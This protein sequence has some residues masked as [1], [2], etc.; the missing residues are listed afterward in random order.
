MN[1]TNAILFFLQT[2]HYRDD[3]ES[4]LFE[5]LKKKTS[6]INENE[7]E[8][9]YGQRVHPELIKKTHA[10]LIDFRVLTKTSEGLELNN[11]RLEYFIK[12][13]EVAKAAREYNWPSNKP[14]PFLYISPPS[15]ITSD[16]SGDIDD[17]SNLLINLVRSANNTISIMS[18]FTNKEGLKSILSPLKACT[19]NPD[20][21]L[22]LTANEE[23]K[24]MI[25]KQIIQQVPEN[26]L[27]NLKLYYC[28]TELLETDNLPHAKLLIID[29]KK[30]YLGSANFTKQGLKSR[31]E[32][33]VELE[34]QQSKTVDKLL[35]MLV[36]QGTFQLFENSN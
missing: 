7:F 18:P 4:A 21:S 6:P 20:I 34:E 32:L 29:S 22:Y 14:K 9:I 10:T 8:N 30:G 3:L 19:N 5:N 33:G 28:S 12:L 35:S 13:T 31:F 15:L 23:D 2:L 11:E 27:R 24:V 25:Y 36:E 1:E 17:I 16:L 26:M